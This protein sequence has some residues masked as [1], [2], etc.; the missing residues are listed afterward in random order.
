MGFGFPTGHPSADRRHLAEGAG[1]GAI[2]HPAVERE[3]GEG[4]PVFYNLY[5]TILSDT[6]QIVLTNLE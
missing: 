2:R 1:R 6:Q 3:V 4:G 5:G